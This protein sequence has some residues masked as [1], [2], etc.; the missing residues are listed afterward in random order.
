MIKSKLAV[1][2]IAFAPCLTVC[3]RAM[4]FDEFGR[5]NNDD[6]AGY[7]AFLVEASAKML[8]ANGH[9]DQAD[10]A[11]ALFNDSGKSGGVSQLAANLKMLNGMNNRNSTNPNNHAPVYQVEDAMALTLKDA[12]VSV[13]V[14]Y[15]VTVS[16]EFHPSGLPR[17]HSAGN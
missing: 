15:L 1:A 9:A 5:M 12:G 17:Q 16:E 3:A 11:I 4:S 8:K 10:K 6:E 7:V 2:L 13:P 14:S